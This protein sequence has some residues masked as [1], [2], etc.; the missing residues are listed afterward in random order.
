[1]TYLVALVGVLTISFSAVF[2]R[3]ASVSPV[4]ATL[5]RAAY[6]I[7]ALVLL[8]LI[9][10]RGDARAWAERGVAFASGLILALDLNLWH[11]SIGMVG[12]GLGTVI[13]NI[14]VA[15]VAL[16][17]WMIDGERPSSRTVTTMAIATSGV[18]LASGLARSDAYGSS[19]TVG[20]ALGVLAGACYAAYILVFRAATRAGVPKSG[21]LLEST[22]GM[23]VGAILSI[24]FDRHFSTAMT[25]HARLWLVA[26]ALI[27]Q[28]FGWMLIATA[29]PKLAAIEASI[30]LLGQ[31]VFAV[32]WGRLIFDERP[33]PIQWAGCALVLLGV[34]T[35]S[36][37]GS[38]RSPPP[39]A[40]RFPPRRSYTPAT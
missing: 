10:R 18:V 21:P 33:S 28:V 38:R 22:V 13:P 16:A 29:L 24:P 37:R 2:V 14:Q 32:L 20:V 40:G 30:L 25:P 27:C 9:Q 26:L 6:A 11:A 8:W 31:P 15:F 7:P 23:F 36:P 35:L 5:Y 34:A 4:T 1:M 17:A 12:A 3:L 39:P 19:P